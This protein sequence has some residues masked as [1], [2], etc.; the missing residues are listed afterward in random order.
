[1]CAESAVAACAPAF[2]GTCVCRG[3]ET[4][5]V[6]LHPEALV[7]RAWGGCARWPGSRRVPRPGGES[8]S[9]CMPPQS[10][11]C[12]GV[13]CRP[14]SRP[15]AGL[16]PRT[17]Q[18][19]PSPGRSHGC[20]CSGRRPSLSPRSPPLAPPGIPG[21]GCRPADTP[22]L[23]GPAPSVTPRPPAPLCLPRR[24]SP[25]GG[26]DPGG[27]H[28]VGHAEQPAPRHRV[29]GDAPTPLRAA[30]R[31]PCHPHRPDT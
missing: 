7:C 22:S 1:M 14:P 8:A 19:L 11:L 30:A 20:P 13:G 16:E 2:A 23:P 9:V 31:C 27:Q 21:A 15:V 6:F 24:S 17:W 28:A 26:E 5:C 29:R 10:L 25:G 12:V 3:V 18:P 4:A